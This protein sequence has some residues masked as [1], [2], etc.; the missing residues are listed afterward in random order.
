[1]ISV[2]ALGEVGSYS[3][4]LSPRVEKTTETSRAPTFWTPSELNDLEVGQQLEIM[5]NLTN[6][7]SSRDNDSFMERNIG[8]KLP[9][10]KDRGEASGRGIK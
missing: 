7:I 9:N 4:S 5:I 10:P 6:T 3:G 8:L 1:M 2:M